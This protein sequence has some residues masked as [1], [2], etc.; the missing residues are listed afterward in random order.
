MSSSD[1]LNSA[2]PMPSSSGV[3]T[4]S[5]DSS[6]RR[7][8]LRIITL[9]VSSS[10]PKIVSYRFC[11]VRSTPTSTAITRSARPVCLTTS[12]GT[13]LST[14]PSTSTLP[15]MITGA[16]TPGMA[17]VARRAWASHPESKTTT[18]AFLMSVATQRNGVGM[19]LKSVWLPYGAATRS[20]SRS[21]CSAALSPE[22]S[23]NPPRRPKRKAEGKARAS[24]LRRN[25]LKTNGVSGART[26][27]QS[28]PST[29]D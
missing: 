16:K 2:P 25:V 22:G 10:T 8:P 15:S 11:V 17:T 23:L 5:A 20:N 24:S 21:A 26:A 6:A 18:S 27:A 12:A 28:T 13:L 4:T 14:P 19:A 1:W 7:V 29:S 9:R 3:S